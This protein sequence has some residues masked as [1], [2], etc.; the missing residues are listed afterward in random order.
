MVEV[1]D[2]TGAINRASKFTIRALKRNDDVSAYN[3]LK[4]LVHM[5]IRMNKCRKALEIIQ[6]AKEMFNDF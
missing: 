4:A 3:S 1:A 6:T 5:Y 2:L